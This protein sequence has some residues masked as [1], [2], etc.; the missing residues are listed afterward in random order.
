MC[1]MPPRALWLALPLVAVACA[2]PERRH[3][4]AEAPTA[5]GVARGRFEP[6]ES[7]AVFGRAVR[8]ARDAGYTVESC[9]APRGALST[10]MREF[11]DA[12]GASTC[13]SRQSFSVVVGHRGVRV[14]VAREVFDGALRTWTSADA[15]AVDREAQAM[16]QKILPAASPDAREA[17]PLARRSEDEP[18]P[19]PRSDAC[20]PAPQAAAK[21]P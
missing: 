16:L 17:A 15:T 12:C 20:V 5:A 9:D 19:P 14:T 10:G 3:P 18:A 2:A 7:D 6:P 1:A 8:A 21:A 11:D 4:H 13:L